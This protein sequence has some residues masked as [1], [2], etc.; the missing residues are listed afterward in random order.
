MTASAAGPFT[1]RQPGGFGPCR[2]REDELVIA[3][4]G[5]WTVTD[6]AADT[7]ALNPR[8]SAPAAHAWLAT[9]RRR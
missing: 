2:V 4:G 6:I 3:F 5:G 8:I 1:D 7:F 9:I